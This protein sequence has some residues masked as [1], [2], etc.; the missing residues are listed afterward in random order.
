MTGTKY[1]RLDGLNSR[2]LIFSQFQRLEVQ[3]QGVGRV[4]FSW[5]LSPWFVDGHLLPVSLG[6]HHSVCVCVLISSSYK[7]TGQIVLGSTLLAP[8]PLNYLFWDPISKGSRLE[9]MGSRSQPM[10]LGGHISTHQILQQEWKQGFRP[11]KDNHWTALLQNPN[12]NR[13]LFLW[14]ATCQA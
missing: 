14:K 4:G 12:T 10:Y 13:V 7:D 5:G 11:L 9:V 2:Q 6:G 8:F 1:H 3:D